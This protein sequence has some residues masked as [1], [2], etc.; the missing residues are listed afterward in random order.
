M[1]CLALLMLLLV[2][3]TPSF[4]RWLNPTPNHAKQITFSTQIDGGGCAQP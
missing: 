4:L 2:T 1:C 3:S